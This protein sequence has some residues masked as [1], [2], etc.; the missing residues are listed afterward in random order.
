MRPCFVSFPADFN[1]QWGLP[2]RKG[3]EVYL[4]NTEGGEI[5][6]GVL[7]VSIICM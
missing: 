4:S 6:K 2:V 5:E 7:K 3:V 1:S